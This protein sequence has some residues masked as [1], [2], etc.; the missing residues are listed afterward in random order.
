MKRCI[1]LLTITSLLICL[2][3]AGCGDADDASALGPGKENV[4][5]QAEAAEAEAE[6][7]GEKFDDPDLDEAYNTAAS[8][9]SS[10]S[11]DLAEIS[12]NKKMEGADSYVDNSVEQY[13]KENVVMFD[14]I[15][16]DEPEMMR[17][18]ILIRNN[19]SSNW[20]VECEV[21]E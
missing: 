11:M 4:S 1:L 17:H 13:G 6:A 19:E 2:M 18:I 8:Y 10:L 7:E 15:T 14:A 5:E 9:Y 20:S 12:V 3:F 16:N 21:L